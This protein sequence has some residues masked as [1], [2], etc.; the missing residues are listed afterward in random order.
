M[1]S[2]YARVVVEGTNTPQSIQVQARSTAEAKKLTEP[3][4]GRVGRRV[5]NPQSLGRPPSWYRYRSQN[6]AK[7][8]SV[9]DCCQGIYSWIRDLSSVS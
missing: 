7:A 4:V 3:K 1:A 5:N 8:G 2:F 9:A 6:V